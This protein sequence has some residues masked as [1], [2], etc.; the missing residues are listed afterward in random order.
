M[1]KKVA[2]SYRFAKVSL[3]YY[4]YIDITQLLKKSW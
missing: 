3:Y 2:K 4:F 1:R